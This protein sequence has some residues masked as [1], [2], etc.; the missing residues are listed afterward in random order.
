MITSQTSIGI[1]E[2]REHFSYP[3]W[4]HS[5]SAMLQ[6]A[7][8]AGTSDYVLLTSP[9]NKHGTAVASCE[10]RPPWIYSTSGL[11][12]MFKGEQTIIKPA[13]PYN[14]QHEGIVANNDA[15]NAQIRMVCTKRRR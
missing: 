7:D 15:I 4:T 14:F 2:V 9:S 6:L 11:W 3:L 13:A 10:F 1:G 12:H 5:V 8:T